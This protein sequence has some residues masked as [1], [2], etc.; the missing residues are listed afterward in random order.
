M[1]MF[2][3]MI[4]LS[5]QFDQSGDYEFFMIS[6]LQACPYVIMILTGVT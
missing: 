2:K 4:E 3:T 5:S 6:S 1:E